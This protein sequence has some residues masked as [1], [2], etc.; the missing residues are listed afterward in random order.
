[1]SEDVKNTDQEK[2]IDL[3][4]LASKVWESRK[5]IIKVTAVSAVLGLIVAFSIPAE[6][7][8]PVK[9]VAEGG[10][11][12]STSGIA[13]LL[14]MG[15]FGGGTRGADGIGVPLYPEVVTT[16]PFLAEMCGIKVQGR[17]MDEPVTLYN[18]LAKEQKAAWWT[19]ILQAPSRFMNWVS[20][21]FSGEGGKSGRAGEDIDIFSLTGEQSRVL[22]VLYGRVNASIDK[23][24]GVMSVAV[25]MQD[26]VISAVVADSIVHKLGEY[27][28]RYRTD[29]ARQDMDYAQKTFDEAKAAYYSAQGKY[30]DFVDRN[31]NI[32]KQ[33][34]QIEEDRLRNEMNLAYGVYNATAQQLETAKMK[35]QEQTPCITVIEPASVPIY[36][37]KPRKSV[38]LIGFMFLGAVCAMGYILSKDLFFQKRNNL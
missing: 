10:N 15:G 4:E 25:T 23:R 33:T 16:K 14:S 26:P 18:Y 24:S 37:S 5:L 13:D 9:M 22:K 38:I 7:I 34:V 8:T 3:M 17:K 32:I 36:Q 21:L 29:K 35:V 2:D 27:I 19:Y 1:M 20:S 11:T 30:A 31:K 6:Y 12:Q 28:I